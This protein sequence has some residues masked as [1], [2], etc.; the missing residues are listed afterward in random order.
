MKDKPL[1]LNV[2]MFAY[3]CDPHQPCVENLSRR[4]FLH[5]DAAQVSIKNDSPK[6]EIAPSWLMP[7]GFPAD[8]VTC[9]AMMHMDLLCHFTLRPSAPSFKQGATADQTSLSQWV[10]RISQGRELRMIYCFSN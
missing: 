8:A 1:P 3:V 5:G 4:D 7:W 10:N 9:W 6:G 2:Q